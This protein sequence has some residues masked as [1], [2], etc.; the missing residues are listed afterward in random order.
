MNDWRVL[1]QNSSVAP[2]HLTASII[3]VNVSRCDLD[4][5]IT[6]VILAT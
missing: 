2:D 6:R 5:L 1:S 4:H 3:E